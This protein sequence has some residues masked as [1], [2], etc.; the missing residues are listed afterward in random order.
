MAA[1]RVRNTRRRLVKVTTST[2]RRR[3]EFPMA[4]LPR[5]KQKRTMQAT[6]RLT[7][8]NSA[9][10]TN[11]I[12]CLLL[13]RYRPR[14]RGSHANSS[15]SRPQKS[16]TTYLLLYVQQTSSDTRPHADSYATNERIGSLPPSDTTKQ[17]RRQ[18]Q[19]MVGVVIRLIKNARSSY[20]LR[21]LTNLTT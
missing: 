4:R 5:C 1:K 21:S 8:P 18:Q 11:I 14:F 15:T 12:F 17:Q 13:G 2:I 20:M 19:T 3:K 10:S 6:S 9:G 16:T 7:D